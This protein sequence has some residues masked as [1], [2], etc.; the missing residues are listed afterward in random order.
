MQSGT[1]CTKIEN[2]RKMLIS[3]G[4]KIAEQLSD[5]QVDFWFEN[6]LVQINKEDFKKRFPK[7]HDAL[8]DYII[9]EE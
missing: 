7:H 4:Y 6:F 5:A 8:V 3:M 9:L 2:K 1:T